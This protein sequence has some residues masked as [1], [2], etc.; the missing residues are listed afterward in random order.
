MAHNRR[1]Y[2]GFYK[3]YDGEFIYVIT[4]ATDADSGEETVVY[5]TPS[6]VHKHKYFTTSKSSFCEN[7]L[8]EG[9]ERPKYRRQTQTKPSYDVVATVKAVGFR[10]PIRKA[11]SDYSP[12]AEER[13]YQTSQTY[14]D[15]AKDLCK[16]YKEDFDL[17]RLCITEKRYIGIGKKEFSKAYEDVMFVRNSLKT[18]LR[19]Y[20]E[21]FDERYVHG[22]SVRKY[23]DKYGL[24]RGS[25]ENTQRKLFVALSALLQKRD[26]T[27]GKIRIQPEY[28][29]EIDEEEEDTGIE[30]ADWVK[31]FKTSD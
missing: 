25:V 24:N 18:A 28:E 8:F 14:Y 12:P 3:R 30:I 4:T 20:K 23:A 21:F 16:H 26:E 5:T 22:L 27:D 29:T 11:D 13:F 31:L 15:Y 2:A 7:V 19:D 10:G 9:K 17:I 6:L 1:V